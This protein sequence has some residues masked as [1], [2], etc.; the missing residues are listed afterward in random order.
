MMAMTPSAGGVRTPLCG[1]S[2]SCACTSFGRSSS[3]YWFPEDAA[4]C[5]KKTFWLNSG[6][7]QQRLE[8]FLIMPCRVEHPTSLEGG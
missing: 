1:E 7:M 8:R 4:W 6:E 3:T 2:E 5:A